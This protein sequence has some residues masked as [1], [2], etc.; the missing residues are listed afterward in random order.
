MELAIHRIRAAAAHLDA[1]ETEPLGRWSEPAGDVLDVAVVEQ[2]RLPHVQ[3][4]SVPLEA[5]L[6]RPWGLELAKTGEGLE[7]DPLELWEHDHAAGVVVHGCEVADL[8]QGEQPLV[9]GVVA[10]PGRGTRRRRRQRGGAR[11]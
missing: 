1:L 7:K 2:E 3:Q 4:H 5:P 11:S 6:G 10:C 9:V 8:G